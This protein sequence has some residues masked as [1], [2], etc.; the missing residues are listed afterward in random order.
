MMNTM[1][2]SANTAKGGNSNANALQT[3]KHPM[4]P[5]NSSCKIV[6]ISILLFGISCS[7]NDSI[8]IPKQSFL[9][10]HG[11]FL[12][13]LGYSSLNIVDAEVGTLISPMTGEV[14]IGPAVIGG[15]GIDGGKLLLGFG[16]GESREVSYLLLVGKQKPW[17]EDKIK[18]LIGFRIAGYIR[19]AYFYAFSESHQ[20][21]I[22]MGF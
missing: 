8:A 12:M 18:T 5:R 15:A 1:T 11:Q 22:G 19:I 17:T 2:N 16:R 9:D 7:A 13:G 6:I 4:I 14:L 3:R 10:R 21:E 20:F